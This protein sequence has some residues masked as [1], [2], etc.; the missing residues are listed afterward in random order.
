MRSARLLLS[1]LA[2]VAIASVV[3]LW[4]RDNFEL[5]PE[6]LLVFAPH[7]LITVMVATI[8]LPLFGIHRAVRQFTSLADCLRIMAA[9]GATVVGSLVIGFLVTRLDAIARSLPIL[10]WLL[11]IAFLIGVRIAARLHHR[12]TSRVRSHNA[13]MSGCETALIVGVNKLTE[14][15]LQSVEQFARD[16]VKVAGLLDKPGMVGGSLLSHPVLGTPEQLEAVLRRLEVHGVFVD[17][18]VIATSFETLSPTARAALSTIGKTTI[19]KIERLDESLGFGASAAQPGRARSESISGTTQA[20]TLKPG[21]LNDPARLRY[22]RI[23]RAAD[24]VAA[25][26]LLILTAPL[27][28]VVSILVAIDVGLPLAFWQQRPGLNGRP[29][30]VY[31]FRTMSE[32]HD[33]RGRRRSDEERVSGIG[34]FLRRTRLDELPQLFSILVGTM[35]FVGPRPLLPV[36]QSEGFAARLSVRPGLTGWAQVKGGRAISPEDKAALDVWYV[37]EM[38]LALD[39][40]ILASTV[41]MVLLGERVTE[42]AIAQAWRDLEAAGVC[43]G[44]DFATMPEMVRPGRG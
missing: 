23:K 30:K 25:F 40:K 7:L 18:I 1:D 26:L 38:S 14:L 39:L 35:S 31:K 24:I 10:Q 8:A 41:P 34:R 27:M 37:H 4:L 3:A 17:R 12:Q 9:C 29:F 42:G 36:D 44:R 20:F 33:A 6:R 11:M 16:R 13:S 22:L 43:A 5:A 19:I 32:A 21:D 28:A 15:Y 2:L